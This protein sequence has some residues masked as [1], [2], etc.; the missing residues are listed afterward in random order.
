VPQS[1][2]GQKFPVLLFLNGG[3]FTHGGP[4][5]NHFMAP[6]VHQAGYAL[7]ATG[8]RLLA[9]GRDAP[10]PLGDVASALAFLVRMADELGLDS[11]RVV[12][13]GHS[14]GAALA[15]GIALSPDMLADTGAN[16]RG[17][18]CL[19]ASLHRPAITG[20]PGASYVLPSGALQIAVTAPLAWVDLARVPMLIGWG[21]R[22][23]QRAR[24]ERSS[25]AMISAMV[26]R[27]VDVEWMIDE[28][29]DHFRTHTACGDREHGWYGRIIDWLQRRA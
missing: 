8:Y 16:L 2:A 13:G 6:M 17:V 5:W 3:G 20:T 28:A 4:A 9:E 10:M 7:A 29:A 14:A 15:A 22:E 18:L 12:V 24:V 23:R 21:G 19:S 26:D 1:T 27:G 11:G 25:I